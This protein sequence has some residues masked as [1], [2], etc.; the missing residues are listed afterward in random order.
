[1]MFR[2]AKKISKR[3]RT[4]RRLTA[5]FE[6]PAVPF[7]NT[8]PWLCY[9]FVELLKDQRIAARPMYAWGVLQGA[10][11]AKVLNVPR[12][13]VVEFGVAGGSGLLSLEACAEAVEKITGIGID[14]FGFDT[15]KGLP[16]PTDYRD[17]P[18]MWFE[19]Q[20][21]MDRGRLESALKRARLRLGHVEKTV[22]DFL[23]ENQAPIGFISF[24]LDLYSSTRAAFELLLAAPQRCLPRV[25]SYF[26]DI[27][28]HSYNEYCGE[29]L[30]IREFNEN[31][32]QR[33]LC[34]I[35]GL[36]YFIPRTVFNDLWPNA[37]YFAHIF[38]HPQ[39]SD[40]DS[41][42]KAV[43]TDIDGRDYRL[44]PGSDWRSAVEKQKRE[45]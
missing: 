45:V 30:A 25:I 11:L 21:P 40:L 26:D 36:K 15:G 27:F 18:N 6:Y 1:M 37:M 2:L 31:E 10:A 4:I 24:D 42:N 43:V 32:K 7:D 12:I 28:G 22:P 38:D 29:R 17:Q 19:G 23:S 8:Y 13:S 33:R 44:P 41:L 34:P 16:K 5:E 3:L 35:H 39:Y 9:T 14:A 20:L